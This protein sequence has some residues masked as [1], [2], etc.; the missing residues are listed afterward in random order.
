MRDGQFRRGV[1][2]F[3]LARFICFILLLLNILILIVVLVVLIV[4]EIRFRLIASGQLLERLL[5]RQAVL[6]DVGILDGCGHRNDAQLGA[7]LVVRFR[8]HVLRQIT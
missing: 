8:F 6:V 1:G 4:R 7:L 5:A 2:V 3:K